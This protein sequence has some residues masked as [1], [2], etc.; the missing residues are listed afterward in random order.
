MS[1]TFPLVVAALF[2]GMGIG[3]S[4][5]GFVNDHNAEFH[6]AKYRKELVELGVG[7]YDTRTGGFNTQACA[8]KE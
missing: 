4:I 8:K 3:V 7:Y 5:A 2:L 1:N 6:A